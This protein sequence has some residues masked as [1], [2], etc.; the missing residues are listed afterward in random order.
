MSHSN[1]FS[2]EAFLTLAGSDLFTNVGPF[3]GGSTLAVPHDLLRRMVSDMP[4]Y[5]EPHL[6]YALELG[7]AHSPGMF[8][9]H[10]PQY[11]I[12]EQGSVRCAAG[13]FLEHLPGAYITQG[14]VDS[15]RRAFASYPDNF[16]PKKDFFSGVLE[17][18][19]SECQRNRTASRTT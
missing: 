12:H 17:S 5:D 16:F 15:V 11:L 13:R 6:I 9:P 18:L 2:Y 4:A 1:E 19:E 3:L 7:G 14:L 10:V 8:A